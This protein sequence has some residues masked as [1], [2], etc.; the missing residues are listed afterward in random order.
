ML[1][2]PLPDILILGDIT[3]KFRKYYNYKNIV[4]QGQNNNT[5]NMNGE[6]INLSN[7]EQENE[8]KVLVINPGDFSKDTLF[9]SVN[10][11]TLE[12]NIYNLK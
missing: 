3:E 5:V 4:N 6:T 11:M 9:A 1:I 8:G 12:S 2:L 7:Q 10:P